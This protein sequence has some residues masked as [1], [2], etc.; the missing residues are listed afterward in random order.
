MQKLPQ[1]I[2][3]FAVSLAILGTVAS[4]DAADSNLLQW[5]PGSC[6]AVAVV[7]MRKLVDSPLGQ[8]EK[9][10]DKVRQAYAEGLLSAPPWVREVVRG[11][12]FSGFSS[13]MPMTYSIYSMDQ[14]SVIADIARH[15]RST[16]EKVAGA[17]AVLS[18]RGIYFVQLA[19]GI[20]GALQPPDRRSVSAWVRWAAS[21]RGIEVSPYLKSAL[22]EPDQS[23]VVI[24]VDMTDTLNR[25]QVR[26]WLAGSPSLN[27][28][29]N[30]D[31]LAGLIASMRGARLSLAVTDTVSGRLRL[32]FDMPIASQSAALKTAILQWLDDA[33]AQ[34]E[35]LVS[36]QTTASEKS[37]TFDAPLNERALR[38]ILSLIQSPHLP[39]KDVPTGAETQA[40]NAV[41]TAGYYDLVCQLL[42]SLIRQN[43]TATNYNSTAL[44]HE[45]SARKIAG[46]S[47]TGV[48]P[49]LVA[50]AQD[51]SNKLLA[52]A[53]S[54]RGVPVEVNQLQKSIRFDTTTYYHWY[55]NSAESGPMYF[56]AWVKSQNNVGDVRAQEADVIDKNADQRQAI[57]NMLREATAEVARRMEYKYK[58]KLKLPQ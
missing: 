24:G 51:V 47:T 5:I 22:E 20:V 14:N 29:P 28:L 17:P 18:P 43:R 45:T 42:N 35:V 32:D 19:P 53:S 46:L 30:L 41:A 48:D 26:D 54:L 7:H 36:A 49:E 38:R 52:L 10:G 33:G 31:G 56:P 40:P 4:A 3:M 8:K 23:L 50:W 1:P 12:T 27:S 16:I 15:E 37:L 25:R 21:G 57:W 44:W 9:W 6:N 39:S 34:M 58:I 2:R 55:A 13:G 11:T